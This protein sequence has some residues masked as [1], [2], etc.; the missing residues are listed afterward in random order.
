MRLNAQK[1]EKSPEKGPNQD[2]MIIAGTLLV[3]D[4]FSYFF[5][6]KVIP[7]VFLTNYNG[8]VAIFEVKCSGNQKKPKIA[9]KR[10]KSKTSLDRDFVF[11]EQ[12]FHKL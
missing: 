2:F 10:P 1:T 7:H 9:V 11:L 3:P 8:S 5:L 6:K 4:F 12:I